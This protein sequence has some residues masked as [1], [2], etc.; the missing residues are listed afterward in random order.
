MVTIGRRTANKSTNLI[1]TSRG[2]LYD[3]TYYKLGTN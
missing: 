3:I 1:D 2:V